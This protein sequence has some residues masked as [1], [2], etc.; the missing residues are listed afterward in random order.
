MIFH[1]LEIILAAILVYADDT[2]ISIRSG[3]VDIAVKNGAIGLLEPWFWKWRKRI[4]IKNAQLQCL[5]N[6]WVTIDTLHFQ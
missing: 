6:D 3:S 5:S 1:E 4:N 2:N